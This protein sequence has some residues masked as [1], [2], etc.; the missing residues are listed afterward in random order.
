MGK[1]TKTQIQER[2]LAIWNEMD[3]LDI[4][5]KE[6][7]EKINALVGD[8]HKEE[9]EKLE[10]EQRQAEAKYDSLVRESAGLSSRAKAMASSAELA[11]IRSNEEKGAKLR[12]MLKN[13]VNKRENATTTLANAVTTGDDQNV[14]ANLEAGGLIPVTI[15]DIIDTKVPGIEL[16]DS[17]QLVTG[18]TGTE[19]IPYSTNDVQFTVNGEVQKVGEQALDFANIQA[20]PVRVAASLAVSHRAIDNAAFD[21]LGFITFKM[22]KGWAIFRALHVY[23]HGAY[24]KLQGP[25]AKIAAADIEE[26][27]L[28]ENIGKNLA[29]KI[30]EMYDL[31]FEGDPELIMDK[32]T[33]VDLAFTPRIPDAHGD[34][35]V[36]EDGKCVGYNYKVSPYVDYSIDA[37]GA[38]TKDANYRYIAI[39]HFG[40][41]SEEQHGE[42]RFN[43]DATS[44]E[45]FNRATVVISMTTDYSLT[46]L[47]SKVNGN[48]NGKPQ[49]FKLIK[50]VPAASNSDI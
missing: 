45:V 13:C 3:N 17:L 41:L 36:I 43:V 37:N 19:I 42:F 8:E 4:Q 1:M 14:N 20:T 26:L 40:Y 6:R 9:R 39:G 44:A 15:R 24:I 5:L 10:A 11:N 35:T 18:V 31:G 2:Q 30:A 25:F 12:E 7:E 22:Q 47:S 49:A 50:L 48:T 32:V 38:A 27:T 33:E 16:P 23:A 34:K 21:I 29:K 46:E 28:D